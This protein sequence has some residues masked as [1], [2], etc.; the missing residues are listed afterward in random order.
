MGVRGRP[1]K[2]KAVRGEASSASEPA[3][4]A[5][6]PAERASEQAG[7]PAGRMDGEMKTEK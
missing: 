7:K 1:F 5:S 4:R 3:E 6:D 2:R